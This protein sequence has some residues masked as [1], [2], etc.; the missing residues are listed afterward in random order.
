[1][2]QKAGKEK[3]NEEGYE[4]ERFRKTAKMH[5]CRGCESVRRV[6][7]LFFQEGHDTVNNAGSNVWLRL[8]DGHQWVNVPPE[9]RDNNTH[10]HTH[11]HTHT[12]LSIKYCVN[13]RFQIRTVK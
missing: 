5:G 9:T 11:I 6:K 1:M 8:N 7:S 4:G 13:N 3:D 10:R 12:S 2:V